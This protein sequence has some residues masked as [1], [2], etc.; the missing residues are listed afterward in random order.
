MSAGILYT[1][2]IFNS[3]TMNQNRK[4]ISLVTP[5]IDSANGKVVC[6]VC[7][8]DGEYVSKPVRGN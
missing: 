6:R 8:D 3:Y 2:N 1:D 7:H 5:I 4:I